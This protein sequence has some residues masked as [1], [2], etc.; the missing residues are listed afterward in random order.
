[1]KK[2]RAA[3]AGPERSNAPRLGFGFLYFAPH[4]GE[5]HHR[6][7]ARLAHHGYAGAELPVV[8]ASDA[9]LAAM[10]RAL[11]AEG[12]AASAVGFATVAANPIDPDPAIRRAAV[13][14]L[15]LLAA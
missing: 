7:F 14:H 11:A 1:M 15:A 3:I 10:R 13:E 5:A 9:E 4:L 8:A 6:W 12:L 2:P